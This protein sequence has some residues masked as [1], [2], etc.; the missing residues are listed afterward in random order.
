MSPKLFRIK[1]KSQR[2]LL[3]VAG[4]EDDGIKLQSPM[5]TPIQGVSLGDVLIDNEENQFLVKGIGIRSNVVWVDM[6]S[7]K[8]ESVA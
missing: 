8:I 3:A 6:I 5:G 4:I 1:G 2:I 7:F